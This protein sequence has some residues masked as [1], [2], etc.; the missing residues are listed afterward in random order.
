M[1][2]LPTLVGRLVTETL[3]LAPSR[4]C[5]RDIYVITRR[6]ARKG[7]RLVQPKDLLIPTPWVSSLATELTA[8]GA[9]GA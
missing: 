8:R 6:L 3:F 5:G 1:K 9:H 4:G 7:D 2:T